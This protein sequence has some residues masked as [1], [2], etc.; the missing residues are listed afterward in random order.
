MYKE[1]IDL[2]REMVRTPSLS[3][4]EEGVREVICRYLESA[5]VDYE[6]IRGN[7]VARSK[8]YDPSKQS[9]V[10][11]AHIDTVP[12]AASYTRDPFDPGC[13]PDTVFGLGSNDD[14]GSVVSMIAAFRHFQGKD[15]PINII[16]AL[17]CEE[18]RSGQNGARWLYCEEGPL[19][20]VNAPEV[21]SIILGE[22]T[23][24]RAATS[25]RGLLVLDGVAHGV[26]GHAGRGEGVNALYIALDDIS[27]LRNH[28]FSKVSPVMGAV[29][30]SINQISSGSAHNVTP[31]SC[32]FVVDIRPTECYTNE[33]ILAE[34][35]AIC[36]STL[37]ARN[38][39]NRSSATR[40]GSALL[41]A[42]E[43]CGIDTFSSPT[44]SDWMRI[45]SRNGIKIGPGE[46]TRS[47]KA[48]EYIKVSEIEGA[49]QTYINLLSTLA[50][51][52]TLE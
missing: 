40:P 20:P 42:A 23:G 49:I 33:E 44:T 45:G 36:R 7:I 26:S 28:V 37:K 3:F 17:T 34:L 35:Q 31:D 8:G 46:S 52:N 43:A 39:T 22:P 32:T 10:L 51:G 2:L 9:V 50:D 25:E 13:D 24:L 16:L 14:G 38:L 21:K 19:G 18:E 11:D 47:H 1:Y 6:V 4:E 15:L 27:K 12:A 29:R 48:D 5:G 30:M 41:K